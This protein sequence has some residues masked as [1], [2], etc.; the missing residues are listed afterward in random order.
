MNSE[1]NN[2]PKP[3]PVC[4]EEVS[5]S[6]NNTEILQNVNLVVNHLDFMAVV[7]PN[8]GGK[9]T[10]IKLILGLLTPQKGRIR[11]FGEAPKHIRGRMGYVQQNF[12]F[13]HQF[14]ISVLEVV[15][16]G[17]LG[18]KGSW[19]FYRSQEK[20]L[21]VSALRE[22]EMYEFSHHPF[23][24]LSGGQM[25]RVMLARALVSDP[26]LLLLDEP[27]AHLDILVENDLY[28]LLGKLNQRRTI[29]MVSHDVGYVSS[30]A[31]RVICI[32]RNLVEH[33]TYEITNQHVQELFGR[34]V[35]SVR[36]EH[37]LSEGEDT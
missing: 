3:P 21:A 20:E 7:G 16:T 12:R 6:Y 33:P 26:E 10:F 29:I 1:I 23:A 11:V 27:T 31:N 34:R 24:D 17:L 25:Q 37:Q 19:G 2:I 5:F 9:T 35:S 15:L 18:R 8:G 36:H 30:R 32:N 28:E 14:P 4:F 13:D 22:V